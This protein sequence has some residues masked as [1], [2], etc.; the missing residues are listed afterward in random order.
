MEICFVA[1]AFCQIPQ[2]PASVQNA[3]SFLP[4]IPFT[5]KIS[6]PLQDFAN[7]TKL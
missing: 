5:A 6:F 7:D 4:Q 3:F 1:G 2:F